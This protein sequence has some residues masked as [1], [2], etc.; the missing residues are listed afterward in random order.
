MKQDI[1]QGRHTIRMRESKIAK[2]RTH[3]RTHPMRRLNER[4]N[5]VVRSTVITVWISI[6][7]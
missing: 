6:S 2:T 3:A 7:E 4:D 5:I 1:V